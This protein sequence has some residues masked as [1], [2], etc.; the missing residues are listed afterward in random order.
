M[1]LSSEEGG[2]GFPDPIT[3]LSYSLKVGVLMGLP[4]RRRV[5]CSSNL[6]HPYSYCSGYGLHS[7]NKVH[8]V[9]LVHD[10][11]PSIKS[12][13][14]RAQI[15]MGQPIDWPL[16]SLGPRRKLDNNHPAVVQG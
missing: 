4:R 7:F 9:G 13:T 2:H 8:E 3:F 12:V 10:D 11:R 14:G 15:K 5:L 1:F 6:L 16:A